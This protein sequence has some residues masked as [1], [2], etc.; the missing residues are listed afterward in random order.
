MRDFYAILGIETGASAG[1][2]RRAYRKLARK[3]HPDINPGNAAAAE[4]FS[5]IA[6]A[7]EVLCHP[8]KRDYYDTHGYY[9][10]GVLEEKQE[11]RLGFS[12]DG[13][14]GSESDKPV[15]SD[16]FEDFFAEIRSLR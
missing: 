4:R 11:R 10:E 15:F 5:R 9:D 13:F 12:F 1:D 14:A 7:Y 2:V 6:E 3:F 8:R 16:L